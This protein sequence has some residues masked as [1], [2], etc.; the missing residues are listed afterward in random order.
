MTRDDLDEASADR[1]AA[2]IRNYWHA[3][4]H[5]IHCWAEYVAGH[6]RTDDACAD[7]GYWQV[8][9]NLWQGRPR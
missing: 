5:D 6:G 4:G 3:R 8:R 2:K 1:L 7:A 9:S